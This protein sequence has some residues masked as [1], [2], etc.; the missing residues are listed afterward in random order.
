MVFLFSYRH[1]SASGFAR[2][3]RFGAKTRILGA[4]FA[5]DRTYFSRSAEKQGI[6]SR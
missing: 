2:F 3:I 6:F 4:F 1:F 5:C